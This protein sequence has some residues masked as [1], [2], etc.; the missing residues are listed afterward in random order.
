MP[1]KILA[2]NCSSQTTNQA[3][4]IYNQQLKFYVLG[5]NASGKSSIIRRFVEDTYK[6]YDAAL[7]RWSMSTKII[8]DNKCV[9]I[10]LW[11]P[12]NNDLKRMF[13]ATGYAR[14]AHGIIIV[15]DVNSPAELN[16]AVELIIES[17]ASYKVPFMLLANK[18]DASSDHRVRVS[19]DEIDSALSRIETKTHSEVLY[20]ETSAKEDINIKLALNTFVEYTIEKQRQID[21]EKKLD[22]QRQADGK[23]TLRI[24]IQRML[25][26]YIQR[27][28]DNCD[29]SG[30]INF[31]H[32]FWLL[33][34]SRACNRKANYFTAKALLDKVVYTEMTLAEIFNPEYINTLR[35]A[36]IET[37]KISGDKHY[38]KRS[39]HS[40]EL[41]KIIKLANR[42]VGPDEK[43]SLLSF[44]SL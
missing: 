22:E 24:E 11:E 18:A 27:V 2:P 10:Q 5:T 29:E 34:N 38:K 40:T 42:A 16:M 32:H 6:D 8:V 37:H 1:K 9:S 26:A 20:A 14:G 21:W 30:D 39:I 28:E 25:N 17:H 31:K 33:S 43:S 36:A 23:S 13:Q 12:V 35:D 3:A 4:P 41:N 15:F 19:Q 44:A 7:G